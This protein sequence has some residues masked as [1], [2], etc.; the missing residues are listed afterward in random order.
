MPG[1]RKESIRFGKA[2]GAGDSGS[3]SYDVVG[4]ATVERVTTRF[5]PGQELD[6]H[7]TPWIKVG[8]KDERDK[9]TLVQLEGK[10]FVDGSDDF[11]EFDVGEKISDGDQI[12]VDFDNQDSQFS[13]NFHL[14]IEIEHAGGTS[15]FGGFFDRLRR[16]F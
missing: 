10:D 12:G 16:F 3:L 11:F 14:A 8:S 7:L 9:I 6:L 2:V 15:R 13:Y 1:E 4:D 5:Y